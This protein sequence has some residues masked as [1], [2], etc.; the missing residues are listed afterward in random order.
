METIG[1]K[2][3][4]YKPSELE[5]KAESFIAARPFLPATPPVEVDLI[6]VHM[7]EI[8]IVKPVELL[9]DRL[10]VAA[11]V[12]TP[13]EMN[14]ALRIDMDQGVM[15]S[16]N[17]GDY[18]I[19]IA[20]E[21]G[22]IEIHRSVMLDIHTEEDFVR[23]QKHARWAVAERDAKYFARALLSPRPMLEREAS[24][25]Y[26]KLVSDFGFENWF[27]FES[28]FAREMAVVFEMPLD[29]AHRRLD[30]YV[31]GLR[32]RLSRSFAA[33]SMALLDQRDEVVVRRTSQKSLS[34]FDPEHSELWQ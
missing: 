15:N 8:K 24:R 21:I 7:P 12:L 32:G 25:I 3:F 16:K 6:L 14:R 13:L 23:L 31:G 30:E 19:A 5:A 2:I 11:M 18:N 33:G 22:H 20:E 1:D 9:A 28:F 26:A 29:E 34:F 17:P 10:K 4:D 27:Q